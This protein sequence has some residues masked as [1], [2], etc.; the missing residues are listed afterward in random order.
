MA[1]TGVVRSPGAR[2]ARTALT[3]ARDTAH[4]TADGGACDR[5]QLAHGEAGARPAVMFLQTCGQQRGETIVPVAAGHCQADVSRMCFSRAPLV[6]VGYG[7]ASPRA[8][9][10]SK[11][12][13]ADVRGQV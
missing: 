2:V 1:D 9:D 5:R 11:R 6:P 13:G 10:A 3:A 8:G 12:E 4:D 7:V